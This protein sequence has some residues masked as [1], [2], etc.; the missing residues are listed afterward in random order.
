[1]NIKF[2]HTNIITTDWEKLADFYIKVFACIP[3]PPKR[4]HSGAWL[5][6][7]TG[8]LNSHFQ[9]V[10]LRLPGQGDNGPTLEIYQYSEIKKSE[11]ALPN[12]QGFSHIAFQVENIP[13]LLELA[14]NNGASKIG[15]QFQ[16]TLNEHQ[17]N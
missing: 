5:D 11:K 15:V 13:E 1:M 10:H 14:I 7:G 8:V 4:G 3:V 17:I 6:K 2:G 16:L 12:K 9:G